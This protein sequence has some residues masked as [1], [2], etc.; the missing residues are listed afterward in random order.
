MSSL[1]EFLLCLRRP[2]GQLRQLLTTVPSNADVGSLSDVQA[3]LSGLCGA[4][5]TETIKCSLLFKNVSAVSE[6]SVVPLFELLQRVVVGL[7]LTAARLS[8]HESAARVLRRECVRRAHATLDAVA[9]FVSAARD[10]LVSVS[11]IDVETIGAVIAATEHLQL[12]CSASANR[13]VAAAFL[14]NAAALVKDARTDLDDMILIED[15]G[16]E[17][18]QEQSEEDDADFRDVAM[19]DDER[20]RAVA[21]VGLINCCGV[22]A[23]AAL[24]MVSDSATTNDAVCEGA[25]RLSEV[26][27]NLTAA[28]CPPQVAAAVD[29]AADELTQTVERWGASLL[30][31]Q[32]AAATVRAALTK[33]AS[34]R[35]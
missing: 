31:S 27:D 22:V 32:P 5:S 1:D 7:V 16:D 8:A 18:E 25:A 34:L 30:A 20:R 19:N 12:L 15:D 17:Q 10:R 21:C 24:S 14:K 9:S 33:L 35:Q 11:A 4:C 3:E 6:T 2:N 23:L 28:L 29:A 26:V 13:V